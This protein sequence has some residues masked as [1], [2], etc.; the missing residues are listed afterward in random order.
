MLK[1]KNQTKLRDLK[2][3]SKKSIFLLPEKHLQKIDN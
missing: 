3:P 1:E 2:K